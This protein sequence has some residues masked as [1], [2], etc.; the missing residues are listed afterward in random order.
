MR[1]LWPPNKVISDENPRISSLPVTPSS[2]T[3]RTL[4]E[5]GNTGDADAKRM[6]GAP[7]S[8]F[9]VWGGHSFPINSQEAI[10]QPGLGDEGGGV[11]CLLSLGEMRPR[12][13]GKGLGHPTS[14][15]VSPVRPHCPGSSSQAGL[16][17]PLQHSSAGSEADSELVL[18][19]ESS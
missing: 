10:H 5:L 13:P 4:A 11:H 15:P 8:L 2:M 18:F 19:V 14:C 1:F 12:S 6:L 9:R 17:L 7:F 16:P 3:Y